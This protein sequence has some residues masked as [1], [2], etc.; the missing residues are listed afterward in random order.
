MGTYLPG[1]GTLEWGAG[2]GLGLLTPDIILSNFYPPHMGE[3]PACSTPVPFLP[4]WMDVVS[5][6]L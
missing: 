4:V 2:V 6:I 1:I 5:L 3:R